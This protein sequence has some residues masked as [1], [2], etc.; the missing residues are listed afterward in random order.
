MSNDL[1][2]KLPSYELCKE[3]FTQ[4]SEWCMEILAMLKETDLDS[5]MF[6]ATKY[7]LEEISLIFE[8]YAK[9]CDVYRLR[10]SL[11]PDDYAKLCD[12]YRMRHEEE[13]I[14]DVLYAPPN[15]M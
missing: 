8:D 9:L 15:L 6:E 4:M 13:E 1:N 14:I 3:K 12:A 2:Q 7:E 10:L 5:K 11:S